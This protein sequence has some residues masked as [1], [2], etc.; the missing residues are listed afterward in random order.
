[1]RPRQQCRGLIH[2]WVTGPGHHVAMWWLAFF[3]LPGLAAAQPSCIA[4]REGQ[5]ACVAGRL[6][7]CRYDTGGSLTGRPS[8]Y[9]W[10]CGALR[11]DCRPDP[12]PAPD[13]SALPWLAV[14]PR[15]MPR[16]PKPP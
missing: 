14:P 9:R 10:D 2:V 5:V 8:A 3:L 15:A 11:P 13:V 12:L 6:C 1:M 16:P 7:A 4:Q